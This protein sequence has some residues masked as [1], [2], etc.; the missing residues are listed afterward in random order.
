MP[1]KESERS[2]L[3]SDMRNFTTAI[4]EQQ[5]GEQAAAR[6]GARFQQ[7]KCAREPRTHGISCLT[8]FAA[9]SLQRQAKIKFRVVLFPRI[10]R[11]KE[12]YRRVNGENEHAS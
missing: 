12:T 3:I 5:P 8:Q 4:L 6:D 9:F 10:G 1:P 7:E 2:R 11:Q